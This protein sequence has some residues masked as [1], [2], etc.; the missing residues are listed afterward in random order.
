[1]SVY[2]YIYVKNANSCTNLGFQMIILKRLLL[3]TI[4]AIAIWTY[5]ENWTPLKL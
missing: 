3:E 4:L 2:T 1:M 5:I